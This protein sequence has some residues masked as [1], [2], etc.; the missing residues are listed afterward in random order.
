MTGLSVAILDEQGRPLANESSVSDRPSK[1]SADAVDQTSESDIRLNDQGHYVAP[2]IIEGQ[3]LGSIAVEGS[4]HLDR[5]KP[6]Y[7]QFCQQA[8]RLGLASDQIQ[9]L[10]ASVDQLVAPGREAVAH[11]VSL[12]ANSITQLCHQGFQLR[13]RVSE[14][15]ALYKLSRLLSAHRDLQQVLDAAARSAAQVMRVKAASIRLLD[16]DR[17]F[18]VAKAVYNLSEQYLEKGP[19]PT[20]RSELYRRNLAG[21]VVY[22]ENMARD[23]RVL[24]PDDA[25][26][27]G[28]MSMLGAPMIYQGQPIGVIR[29]YTRRRREFTAY[30]TDMLQAVAGLM[31]TAIEDA[32][33]HAEHL[34]NERVQRQLDMASD[35]QKRMMPSEP[36]DLFPFDIAARYLP[37][38]ELGGDFYDF[39][40][41]DGHLGIA[42]GDVVGKGV[43]AS[44]LM[45]SVR[46]F[47]RAF[48]Q[49]VYDLA[50]IVSQVNR[51]MTQGTLDNEF[52]TLFYGVI[53][54]SNRRLTYC[55]AGHEPPLLLRG[56]QIIR[57][58]V[59]GMIV[60]ID[61]QQQY[62]RAVVDLKRNDLLVIYTDGLPDAQSFNG[63]RFQRDRIIEAIKE[64]AEGSAHDVLSHVL[65]QMR[66][67]VGLNRNVDDTTI[68]T[69]KVA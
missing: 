9:V 16:D 3:Q 10:R 31:A 43:A 47:L 50:E 15:S 36:P 6:H 20:D 13:Q 4:P 27:E 42:V 53:D 57:L 66:R 69:V 59:G 11:F 64:A 12:W 54:P 28:L 41:L 33:L 48:A 61:A 65:W 5:S 56:G 58:E 26:R 55:N 29:L 22:V 38:F 18:L 45:A 1:P 25:R 40:P 21:E 68:V 62:E 2:I 32:R 7:D 67:F 8:Q 19:I 39:V 14:L 63:E 23:P 34:E 51:A 49:D 30:E 46:A 60:G 24:Y 44:L 52:V 37:S 35:V 17:K